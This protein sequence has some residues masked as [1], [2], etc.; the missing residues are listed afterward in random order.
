MPQVQ[1]P[2]HLGWLGG[3]RGAAADR[4]VRRHGLPRPRRLR[5]GGRALHL[6]VPP[7][8]RSLVEPKAGLLKG[9]IPDDVSHTARTVQVGLNVLCSA[10]SQFLFSSYMEM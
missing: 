7:L 2:E 1:H 4:L 6:A 9:R 5:A 10:W 8:Q 3:G